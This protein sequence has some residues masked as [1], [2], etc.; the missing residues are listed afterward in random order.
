MNPVMNADGSVQF[1]T[2]PVGTVMGGCNQ[3][4]A[5]KAEQAVQ[6]VHQIT[7]VKDDTNVKIL[8][9]IIVGVLVVY[10]MKYLS[11]YVKITFKKR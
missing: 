11:S 6:M 10:L 8:T 1:N 7:G 9:G 5:S 3:Q 2:P 4:Q